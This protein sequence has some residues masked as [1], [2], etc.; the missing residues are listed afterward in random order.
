MSEKRVRRRWSR[1]EKRRLAERARRLRAKG[2]SLTAIASELDVL[3]G[4]LRQWLKR[5]DEEPAF[6]SV[7]VIA[8]PPERPGITVRAPDGFV[9]EGLDVDGAALLRGMLG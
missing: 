2:L 6:R 5:L 9:F 7:E 8:P 4:S 3:E 1:T